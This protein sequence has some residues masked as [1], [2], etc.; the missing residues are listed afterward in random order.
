MFQSTRPHG[1]RPTGRWEYAPP[2][3]FQ[4]TRPH[5]ARPTSRSA[6]SKRLKFQSTRPHGAR[7][8][9]K[10]KFYFKY[11]S[12]HAPARGATKTYSLSARHNSCF[13]PR[14]R[15]GRDWASPTTPERVQEFQ[16]TRPHGAR[17]DVYSRMTKKSKFQSTRPHGARL[18]R[19]RWLTLKTQFQY[20]GFHATFQSTRPHG[21]RPLAKQDDRL[22]DVSIHAPARGATVRD[23]RKVLSQ[24][25][26]STRPHGARRSSLETMERQRSFNPRARTGRDLCIV[27]RLTNLHV[28]QSTRPH[29][30]RLTY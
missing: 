6:C 1:A 7:Q 16:S 24:V 17:P 30:A 8:F 25:F 19:Q 27:L 20:L 11:V 23:L 14:A 22:A 13:N 26:Q 3:E 12:I 9:K 28:F 5:G 10:L 21:A 4:S 15:T 29:G 2:V 18:G